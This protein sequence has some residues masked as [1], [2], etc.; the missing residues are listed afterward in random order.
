MWFAVTAAW[1][2]QSD[3]IV[4]FAPIAASSRATSTASVVPSGRNL[5][6]DLD[7]GLRVLLPKFDLD[8][9]HIEVAPGALR[10]K[11]RWVRAQ[12]IR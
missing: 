2:A 12:G 10:V 11:Q 1:V 7:L 4:Y 8:T 9:V 6:S 3:K 5:R